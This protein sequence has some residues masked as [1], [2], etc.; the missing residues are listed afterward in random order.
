VTELDKAIVQITIGAAFFACFSCNYSKVPKREMKRTKLICLRNI[1]FFN[2]KQLILAPSDNLEL[3][4]SM[5][6]MFQM[7]KNDQ[8]YETVIHG[9]TDDATICPAVQW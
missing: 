2:D 9:R 3:A 5:V 7:Q 6:V 8:K 1:R 4:D